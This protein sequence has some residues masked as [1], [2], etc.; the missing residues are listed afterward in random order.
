MTVRQLT[1]EMLVELKENH[2]SEKIGNPSYGE[3]AD[4]DNL[5]SDDEIFAEY[6]DT[7]FSVDDFACSAVS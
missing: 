3:L 1:K 5:V 4:A 2:L 7:E 6:A